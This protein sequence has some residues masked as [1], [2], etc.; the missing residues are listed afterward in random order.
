[1]KANTLWASLGS[2]EKSTDLPAPTRGDGDAG[3]G[4][5]AASRAIPVGRTHASQ[6]VE[7]SQ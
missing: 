1:M 2:I 7:K 3:T 5:A 4:Q 6:Y